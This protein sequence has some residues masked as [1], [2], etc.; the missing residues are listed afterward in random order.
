MMCFP[1]EPRLKHDFGTAVSPELGVALD[2]VIEKLL[3]TATPDSEYVVPVGGAVISKE[4]QVLEELRTQ[5]NVE[6]LQ[7]ANGYGSFKLSA[8]G[9]GRLRSS[10]VLSPPRRVFQVRLDLPL[11]DLHVLELRILLDE[12]R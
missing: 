7:M 9:K 8:L 5:G 4:L 2:E 1:V 6:S 11:K 10:T 3:P 12:A